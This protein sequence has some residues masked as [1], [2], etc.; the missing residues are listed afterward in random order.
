MVLESGPGDDHRVGHGCPPGVGAKGVGVR[1]AGSGEDEG[2]VVLI[3]RRAPVVCPG[4]G[5]NVDLTGDHAGQAQ[6]YVEEVRCPAT[7]EDVGAGADG[8]GELAAG[9]PLAQSGLGR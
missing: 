2:E 3:Q 8:E 9:G 6:R 4:G 5:E 1:G 7:V